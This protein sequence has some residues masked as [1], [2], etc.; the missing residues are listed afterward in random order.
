MDSVSRQTHT[1]KKRRR[2]GGV[3][4][5]RRRGLTNHVR[6]RCVHGKGTPPARAI[7]SDLQ[8]LPLVNT[9]SQHS[10][11]WGLASRP[12]A[13]CRPG[14]SHHNHASDN[15]IEQHAI[16]QDSSRHGDI[17]QQYIYSM[18]AATKA[19]VRVEIS[20]FKTSSTPVEAA[21]IGKGTP[22][23]LLLS[24]TVHY[25]PLLLSTAPIH[26][27]YYLPIHQHHKRASTL[28]SSSFALRTRLDV[29]QLLTLERPNAFLPGKAPPAA[30]LSLQT[31]R[32]PRIVLHI[33][34]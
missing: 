15:G 22:T 17:C 32:Q 9:C 18:R 26:C 12:Q 7:Q 24:T 25:C 10:S 27:Y 11:D 19:S 23:T 34:I 4:F 31:L 14:Y 20:T 8:L 33:S 1:K 21:E 30:L 13:N 3:P 16:I 2:R 6:R 28:H 29:C 5:L